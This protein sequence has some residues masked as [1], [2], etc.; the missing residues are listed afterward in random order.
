MLKIWGRVNSIN[1]Q[2]V[3]WLLAEL[4]L[5]FERTDAGLHFGAVN[6]DW[7]RAM[8]PNG[9]VPTI[10]DDGFIL[11]ESNAVVRYLAAKHSAGAFHPADARTRADADRWMDWCTTTIAP[12]MTP[13]FWGLIRTPAEKRDSAALEGYRKEMD[14]LAG[15]LDALLAD[16]RPY[17]CGDTLT[18]GDIPLGCFTYRWYGMPI[19][20][21][22]LPHLR[23][24]Y[25]RLA[26]RPAF[27]Q[28]VMLP[29][30]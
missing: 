9:R 20:R 15:V 22:E 2:K 16:G 7:Y 18:M 13:L 14:K 19:E 24:W 5:P 29:L 10:D 23:A 4:K 1:V 27:R 3:M 26:A 17:L 21:A 25:E 30:T 28:H 12:V 6:E 11:W 8:N